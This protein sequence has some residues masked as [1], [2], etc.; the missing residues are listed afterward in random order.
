VLL[1]LRNAGC[2]E[3]LQELI[4]VRDLGDRDDHVS[5]LGEP[6]GGIWTDGREVFGWGCPH[7][8]DGGLPAWRPEAFTN[9]ER[10]SD[11]I[12]ARPRARGARPDGPR[13]R[14]RRGGD[15]L[16]GAGLLV[17]ADRPFTTPELIARLGP[18]WRVGQVIGAGHFV[19]LFAAD[20]VNAMVDQFLRLI[21]AE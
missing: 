1:S 3:R 13:V 15:R 18:N 11:R 7:L 9:A 6:Y 20:Q 5:S 17:L 21:G 2:R 8:E 14:Q 19:Q 16:Q 4:E 12:G 10:R